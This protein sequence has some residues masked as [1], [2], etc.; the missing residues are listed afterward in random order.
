[1]RIR[2]LLLPLACALTYAACSPQGAAPPQVAIAELALSANTGCGPTSVQV[3]ITVTNTTASAFEITGLR[4]DGPNGMRLD[5]ASP[6]ASFAAGDLRNPARRRPA[7]G[8]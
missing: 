1:M 3:A 2:T 5:P 6:P 8:S 7:I 4:V